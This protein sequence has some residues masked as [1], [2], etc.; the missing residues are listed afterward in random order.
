[1]TFG[2]KM[3][4][5]N[6]I[7]FA[8]ILSIGL[9]GSNLVPALADIETTTVRTSVRTEGEPIQLKSGV[10]YVLID[11]ATGEVQSNF[12][13]TQQI[14]IQNLPS[15]AVI[16]E[17]S[18]G[19][20]VAT[21]NPS[22]QIISIRT[23]PS[24]DPLSS[25]IDARRSELNQLINTA[26][27]DKTLSESQAKDLRAQLDVVG[28]RQADETSRGKMLSYSEAIYLASQLNDISERFV[29]LT[30]SNS[31]PPLIGSRFVIKD[32]EVIMNK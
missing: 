19:R 8:L 2:G 16:V 13:P 17:Q 15:G 5:S 30:H 32:N 27:S 23:A 22:G 7:T 25:S 18:T 31:L 28:R 11:P 26:L 6:N 1:M 10:S 9:I 12:D 29:S 20:P 3:M 24:F 21:F 14:V 4:S